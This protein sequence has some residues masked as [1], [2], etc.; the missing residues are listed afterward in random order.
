MSII[1]S[2]NFLPPQVERICMSG[3]PSGRN[4]ELT[5]AKSIAAGSAETEVSCPLLPEAVSVVALILPLGKQCSMRVRRNLWG[6]VVC[7]KLGASV[8]GELNCKVAIV[9]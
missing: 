5:K 1:I 9:V 2:L 3:V 7:K 4:L 8:A 6:L